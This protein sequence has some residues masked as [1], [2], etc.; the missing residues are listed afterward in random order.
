MYR[1]L[2]ILSV[3]CNR[4]LIPHAIVHITCNKQGV[5]KDINGTQG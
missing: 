3:D 2:P 4:P 1:N 5:A